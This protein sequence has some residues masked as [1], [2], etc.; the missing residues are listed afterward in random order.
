MW[1]KSAKRAGLILQLEIDFSNILR[2]TTLLPQGFSETVKK[3]WKKISLTMKSALLFLAVF[4]LKYLHL[5]SVS[6]SNVHYGLNNFNVIFIRDGI[7]TGMNHGDTVVVIWCAHNLL[8]QVFPSLA[9][10]ARANSRLFS[11]T[12]SEMF[13]TD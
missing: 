7:Q 3:Y 10:F 8:T 11:V 9:I 6:Q 5:L 13:S 2:A 1:N 4:V 12:Q